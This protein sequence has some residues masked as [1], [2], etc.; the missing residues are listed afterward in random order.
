MKMEIR[1]ATQEDAKDLLNIYAYYVEHTAITFEHEVPTLEEF[2]CRIKDTLKNY[3]YLVA[4][5]DGKIAGY[6]YAGRFRTRASYAWSASSSIYIDR[7]YHR[8]G[9]GKRLYEELESILVKQNVVNVYAGAADPVEE[10]EYLTRNSEHF[11]EA[12]GYKVVARYHECG[13]KFGR[14]Y[15]LL[16]MEKIIGNRVCPPKEFIPFCE[17]RMSNEKGNS[18]ER[19]YV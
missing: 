14:W 11:H 19:N 9:I 16:E 13:S 17:L 2:T 5:V 1:V 8:M 12:I 4:L 15:N 6:I 3:P 7:S 18:N 10:D